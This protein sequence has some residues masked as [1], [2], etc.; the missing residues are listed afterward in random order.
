MNEDETYQELMIGDI[1]KRRDYI[2]GLV[3]S[4]TE[5]TFQL[6]EEFN[7]LNSKLIDFYK[8]NTL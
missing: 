1:I 8:N 3:S 5:I 6:V 2:A 7:N 4:G